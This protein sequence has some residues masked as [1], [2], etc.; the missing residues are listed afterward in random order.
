MAFFKRQSGIIENKLGEG[1]CEGGEG[2]GQG[3]EWG[4]GWAGM[5][6][7]QTATL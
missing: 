1:G 2:M 5:V 4:M 3:R 6:L 7:P